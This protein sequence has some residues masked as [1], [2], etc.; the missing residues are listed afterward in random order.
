MQTTLVVLR[1]PT[2]YLPYQPTQDDLLLP[3]SPPNPPQASR[4]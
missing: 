3:G 4:R 1:M 2:S